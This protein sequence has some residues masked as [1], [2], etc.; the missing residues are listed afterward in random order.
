[1][2]ARSCGF[3]SLPRYQVP[4]PDRGDPNITDRTI[5][6]RAQVAE[7]VYAYV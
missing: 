5:T 3:K 1:V 7:L 4:S 6:I 2:T